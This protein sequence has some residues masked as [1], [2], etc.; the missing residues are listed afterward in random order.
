MIKLL[1][2]CNIEPHPPFYRFGSG[3]IDMKYDYVCTNAEKA[4]WSLIYLPVYGHAADLQNLIRDI[5]LKL[6]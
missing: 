2:L 3:V 6:F 5:A 1:N 4:G